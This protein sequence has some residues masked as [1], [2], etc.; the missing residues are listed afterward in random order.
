MA[1]KEV[2]REYLENTNGSHNKFYEVTVVHKASGFEVIGRYGK[3][4]NRGRAQTKTRTKHEASAMFQANE[5]VRSKRDK[6][7]RKVTPD[8]KNMTITKMNAAKGPEETNLDRFSDLF[9]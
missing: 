1:T 5:L 7:Y 3:I 9:D 6:G 2:F 4:G 8:N